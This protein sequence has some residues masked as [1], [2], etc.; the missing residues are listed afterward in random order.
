MAA[1]S[2]LV[3]CSTCNRYRAV[4][5]QGGACHAHPPVPH[6]VGIDKMGRPISLSFWPQVG[7]KDYCYEH[8]LAAG[9]PA[10]VLRQG[11]APSEPVPPFGPSGP[12]M[13]ANGYGTID[14]GEEFA[15]VDE[16]TLAEAKPEGQA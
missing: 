8:P 12:V 6:V 14:E 13:A 3:A 9:V 15:E 2:P 4:T 16:P 7:P 5:P 1:P 11:G 10:G